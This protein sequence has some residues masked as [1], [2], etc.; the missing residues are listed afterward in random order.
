MARRIKKA[1]IK[2]IS[3]VPAG[4][5]KMPVLY[6]DDGAIEISALS[7]F[8]D[9][10]ELLAVVY[11]PEQRDSQG[12][13]AS[14]A[15][16]K[17]MAYDFIANGANVD[18]RHDNKPV[19]KAQARVAESFLVQ[20]SD[21][22]FAGWKNTEGQ[23]VDLAGAWA[24]VIQIDD[25]KLRQLYRD[26]QWNG[27]SM[28]GTAEVEHEKSDQ[29]D[30]FVAVM[31]EKL[32]IPNET[33][34]KTENKN[35]DEKTIS[36]AVAKAIG[37][38]MKPLTEAITKLAPAAPEQKKTEDK[39]AEG[40]V[41]PVYKGKDDDE[42]ALA[43][44]ERDLQLFELRKASDLTTAAGIKAHRAAVAELKKTWAVEDKA[45]ETQ[46]SDEDTA[47]T[48]GETAEGEGEAEA[49][50]KKSNQPVAKG[51]KNS[52]LAIVGLSKADRDLYAAGAASVARKQPKTEKA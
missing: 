51:E 50:V 37:D 23:A 25:P 33:K 44:F 9:Q 11:A 39:K 41:A 4:A 36:E 15:V 19:T 18:I 49:P 42:K 8:D 2:F 6:K 30:R 48:D 45:E 35:M 28:G 29:L 16:V 43:A 24:T 52:K 1:D 32:G 34:T 20:K 14:A 22:R 3:L 31:C 7:K 47:E 46:M 17:Q 38:A 26:K 40:P 27:V 12:D 10:G 21:P 13:I 5:N